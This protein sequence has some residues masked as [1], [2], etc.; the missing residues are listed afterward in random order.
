MRKDEGMQFDI[1]LF[2][3][4]RVVLHLL[5]SSGL[6]V[7]PEKQVR[8]RDVFV[9]AGHSTLSKMVK[10]HS[11]LDFQRERAPFK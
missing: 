5:H 2:L 3:F 9:C 11:I 6:C 8:V 7:F 10:G 1:R 4:G